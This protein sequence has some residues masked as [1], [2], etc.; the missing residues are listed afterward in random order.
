MQDRKP[1]PGVEKTDLDYKDRRAE[2]RPRTGSHCPVHAEDEE[3]RR[4]V[5]D[6]LSG[7]RDK[8]KDSHCLGPKMR[9]QDQHAVMVVA[10]KSREIEESQ[11][12]SSQKTRFQSSR[13]RIVDSKC[14]DEVRRSNLYS[15]RAVG[16]YEYEKKDS[17]SELICCM[18]VRK[19]FVKQGH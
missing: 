5:G 2:A 7:G 4:P 15:H 10:T 9:N 14:H 17:D 13:R 12:K 1:L 11:S 8:A 18:Q 6:S 19:Y 3:S 16:E